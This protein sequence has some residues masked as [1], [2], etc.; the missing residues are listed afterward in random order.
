MASGE[1][2]ITDLNGTV[3]LIHAALN[4]RHAS[5]DTTAAFVRAAVSA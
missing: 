2:T 5:A 4:A 3:S 1:F